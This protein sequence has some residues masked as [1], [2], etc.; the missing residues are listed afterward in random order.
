VGR[1]FPTPKA[2]ETP[3]KVT[4]P[5]LI[6]ARRYY[7]E[8]FFKAEAE[9]LW[10][11]VWQMA[12][13]LEEIAEVGDWVEYKN[14]DKS[15]IV[16]RTKDGVKAFHNVCTHR[17][18]RLANGHGNCGVQG[19]ICPFHGWRWNAEGECTFVWGRQVWNE[20]LLTAAEIDLK[21]VRVEF[22][23]GCA[24]INFD[25]DAPP[26][27]ETIKP[28]ADRLAAYEL[29]KL[30]V[31]WWYSAIVPCNWKLAMEAFMEGYHVMRTHPQLHEA[32][33][34]GWDS[35]SP[36]SSGAALASM[37]ND[38]IVDAWINW[39]QTLSDGMAG[40][41]HARDVAVAQDLKGKVALPDDK[42][43]AQIEWG[44]V[45]RDEL[46]KRLHAQNIQIPDLNGL[47][48]NHP[49]APVQY[50]FPHY[51]MLPFFGNMSSYRIRPLTEET[52]LFEI[53]SMVRYPD[54][55][56][57]P[58]PVAPVPKRHDD[59]AFPA[60]PAQDYSN[61]PI[62]QL[63]LHELENFRLARDVEGMISNYQRVIDGFLGGVET[64][65]LAK[66]IQVASGELDD[67]IKDIGF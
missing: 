19:F 51:F 31:E 39:H 26:L 9:L 2:G 46:T 60:I 36:P 37:S 59:P 32:N 35:Y 27:L 33:L 65:K 52:C 64:S 10:P 8:E 11:R 58:R 48:A 49:A 62:Q 45:F 63:G 53:W 7:D 16:I 23:G 57:R 18:V 56:K 12:C 34:P 6:P 24:F 54:G 13:R 25:D 21:P 28:L 67:P 50:L 29:D 44:R 4:N 66:G 30:S 14:L 22:W 5:E 20:E 41:V 1:T 38:D 61:L 40:M 3:L 47:A 17:G 43:A 15:V 55:E 42:I